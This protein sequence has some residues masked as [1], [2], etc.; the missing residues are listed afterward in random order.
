MRDN[1]I[2]QVLHPLLHH[3]CFVPTV[4][5][6]RGFYRETVN[7]YGDIL[8]ISAPKTPTVRDMVVF[9][10]VLVFAQSGVEEEHR[11]RVE[12]PVSRLLKTAG[13]G[14][15]QQYKKALKES[16]KNLNYVGYSVHPRGAVGRPEFRKV[17]FATRAVPLP[18]SWGS[19]PG[20]LG[21]ATFSEDESVVTVN[22]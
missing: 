9:L 5:P 14:K 10:A 16:L 17:V 4:R 12:I 22:V 13:M 1:T 18:Y 6:A 19:F 20:L 8:E 3:A 15:T 21:D 2:V 7:E 11:M